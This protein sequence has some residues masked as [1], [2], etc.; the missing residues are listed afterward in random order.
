M[1]WRAPPRTQGPEARTH[2]GAGHQP[3][4]FENAPQTH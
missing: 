2:S 3:M 4:A 1:G